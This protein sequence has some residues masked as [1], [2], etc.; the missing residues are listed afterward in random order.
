[1]IKNLTSLATVLQTLFTTEADALAKETGLVQRK[2]KLTGSVLAQTLVFGWLDKPKATLEQL[3]DAAYAAGVDVSPQGIDQRITETTVEFFD[4]LLCQ[5]LEYAC[6]VPVK[7]LPLLARFNGVYALDTT[8]ITLPPSL[9]ALYP[10]LGGSTPDASRAAC[11][12]QFCVELSGQGIVDLQL[13]GIRT[14]DLRFGLAQTSLPAGSLRL[15]DLGFFNLDLLAGYAAENV[16][17][18]SRWK[19]NMILYDTDQKALNLIE[20]L[21][22]TGRGAVDEWVS[23]GEKRVRTR[24]VALRVPPEVASRRR[25]QLLARKRKKGKKVGPGLLALCDWEVSITNVPEAM[26]T[27]E[28]VAR[29]RRLR[30][31]QE[32]MFK[33]LK[34]IGKINHTNGTRPER[35]LTELFAKLLGQVVSGWQLMVSVGSPVTWSW[36]RCSQR[37]QGFWREVVVELGSLPGLVARLEQLAARLLRG[38]RKRRQKKRPATFQLVQSPADLDRW[39]C[40]RFP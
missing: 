12:L 21:E 36:Y 19:P 13:A 29:L 11:G 31:Q 1:M 35:V 34:S 18:I 14:N 40:E 17:Y 2:R 8:D 24:L 7:E 22:K 3:T 16:Y 4:Q 27:P 39:E 26:L 6:Q 25:E 30:W 20:Y 23:V 15:A 38:G 33:Q 28:E 10:G 37:V 32:L 9:A 5:A